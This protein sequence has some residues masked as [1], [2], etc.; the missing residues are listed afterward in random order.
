MTSDIIHQPTTLGV[1]TLYENEEGVST[2]TYPHLVTQVGIRI[3]QRTCIDVRIG[4]PEACIWHPIHG[5][6]VQHPKPFDA[7]ATLNMDCRTLLLV[8]VQDALKGSEFRMCV[9]WSP[10]SCSYVEVDGSIFETACGVALPARIAFET[11]RL[12]ESDKYPQINIEFPYG[13]TREAYPANATKEE[14]VMQAVEIVIRTGRRARVVRSESETI[15]AELTDKFDMQ[16]LSIR[17]CVVWAESKIIGVDPAG[18]HAE[19][20]IKYPHI[21]IC[22]QK[23]CVLFYP[24]AMTKDELIAKAADIAAM[25]GGARV[26]VVWSSSETICPGS[27]QL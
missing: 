27:P 15:Y 16:D 25:M 19:L 23:K 11:A 7:D 18:W 12:A 21:V 22:G 4:P 9:V 2:A 24:D 8:G 5:N 1:P 14:I 20:C 3:F 6:F 17:P 13:I 26:C 10:T